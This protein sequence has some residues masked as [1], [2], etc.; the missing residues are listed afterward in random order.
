MLTQPIFTA[1]PP[2]P[3]PELRVLCGVPLRPL[4][5][6][7]F[8]PHI[9]ALRRPLPPPHTL[10][11]LL[12]VVVTL[13]LLPLTSTVFPLINCLATASSTAESVNRHPVPLFWIR[14]RVWF[15]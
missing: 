8:F 4:R 13:K 6:K 11:R 10:N 14:Y 5:F 12:P 9:P 1:Q 3:M 15:V 2:L 7:T